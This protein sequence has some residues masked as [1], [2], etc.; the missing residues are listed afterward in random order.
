MNNQNQREYPNKGISTPILLSIVALATII[1][2]GLIASL[3]FLQTQRDARSDL[4]PTEQTEMEAEKDI[5]AETEIFNGETTETEKSKQQAEEQRETAEKKSGK[6]IGHWSANKTDFKNGILNKSD[7]NKQGNITLM[8]SSITQSEFPS[9]TSCGYNKENAEYGES[10]VSGD[11]NGDGCADLIVLNSKF[12]HS[13]IDFGDFPFDIPTV[14]GY[15]GPLQDDSFNQPSWIKAEDHYGNSSYGESMTSGDF[16]GDG[17]DD[18]AIGNPAYVTDSTIEGPDYRK[19]FDYKKG[20]VYVYYGSVDGLLPTFLLTPA[21]WS[22]MSEVNDDYTYFGRKLDS[23]DF[24]GDGYDDLVVGSGGYDNSSYDDDGNLQGGVFSSKVYLYCGGTDGL[25]SNYSW[26]LEAEKESGIN[27]RLA[28]GDFNKNGYD[29]LVIGFPYPGKSYIYYGSEKGPSYSQ[30][31][32][33]GESECPLS[34]YG[35]SFASLDFNGDK[36]TDF[37]IGDMFS[38][39]DKKERIYIHHG[40]SEGLSSSFSDVYIHPCNGLRSYTYGYLLIKDDFNKDNYQDL[41]ISEPGYLTRIGAS[42]VK[43]GRVYIYYGSP[44]GILFEHFWTGTGEAGNYGNSSTGSYGG[45]LVSGDFND[46]GYKDLIIGAPYYK[47]NDMVRVG[48][49]YIYNGKPSYLY[50]G[51]FESPV[52]DLG[53]IVDFNAISWKADLD[54]NTFIKFQLATNND[55]ETWNFIG[56]DGTANTYYNKLNSEIYYGHDGSQYVK[57]KVFFETTDKFTSPVLQEVKIN[58]SY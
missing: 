11:F 18:L 12:S 58:Y 1:A 8:V 15:Y 14:Y 10:L 54:A 57:Y 25:S 3:Q 4:K 45:S 55:N 2:G 30:G 56:P 44:K 21:S 34:F 50:S 28:S 49:I 6:I 41:A 26:K 53:R 13:D 29:D 47:S 9:F 43:T 19:G 36:Y 40:S 27:L 7:I 42:S 51:E 32:L 23:G 16:N 52:K 46:D 22:M 37:V 31:T 38:T 24:N 20:K 17:Y 39:C 33:F 5:G 35:G 48:K